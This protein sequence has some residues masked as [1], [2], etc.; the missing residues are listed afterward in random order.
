[1]KLNNKNHAFSIFDLGNGYYNLTFDTP[2]YGTYDVK[3][4]LDFEDT[5]FDTVLSD[6]SINKLGF[7]TIYKDSGTSWISDFQ[8]HLSYFDS[9][10]RIGLATDY[11]LEFNY[12][13]TNQ[14]NKLN[15][16]GTGTKNSVMIFNT[17]KGIS[18]LDRNKKIV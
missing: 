2:S 8:S 14:N 12:E 1:M 13:I 5:S 3:I 11:D 6:V 4:E 10:N 16:S 17:K 15:I 7:N 18:M 9:D